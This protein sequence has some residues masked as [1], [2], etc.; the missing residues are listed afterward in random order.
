VQLVLSYALVLSSRLVSEFS[1]N[2]IADSIPCNSLQA[3]I[4]SSV[5]PP[6]RPV[7][8]LELPRT[9]TRGASFGALALTAR[10]TE[11]AMNTERHIVKTRF[12]KFSYSHKTAGPV[13][14]SRFPALFVVFASPPQ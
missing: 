1:M 9:P 8:L 13:F 2:V 12:V 3:Q 11:T 4:G 7:R 6:T 14:L 5:T 10:A